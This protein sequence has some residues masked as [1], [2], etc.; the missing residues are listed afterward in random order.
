MGSPDERDLKTRASQLRALAA[1]IEALPD[2][3]RDFATRSM[4]DWEG[5]HADRT[6]G[7][8]ADWRSKC[9]TIAENLRQEASDCD[10]N[11]ADLTGKPRG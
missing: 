4:K 6:R 7:A 8:L 1:D 10:R 3:A 5:P 2:K 11:A 9:R